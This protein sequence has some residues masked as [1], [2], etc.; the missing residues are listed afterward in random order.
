MPYDITYMWNLKYDTNELI[1]KT[2]TDSQTQKTNLWLPKGKEG[3]GI[4]QEFG[5]SRHKL[6][7]IKQG[8]NKVLLQSKGK[9]IQYLL[10]NYNGEKKER[11]G[12]NLGDSFCPGISGSTSR[13]CCGPPDWVPQLAKAQSAG[14]LR[15]NY[16][17]GTNSETIKWPV[18]Q[19]FRC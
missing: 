6:L 8:T 10:I 4:N 13:G 12:D 1:Y 18:Q 5:I 7:Y 14:G 9:Y 16:S 17:R 2:E 15:R 19:G 11:A 3:G